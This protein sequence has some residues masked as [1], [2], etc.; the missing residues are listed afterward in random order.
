MWNIIYPSAAGFQR[1]R[2]VPPPFVKG[3]LKGTEGLV[4]EEGSKLQTPLMM[5]K[6]NYSES[7]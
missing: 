5:W 7:I 6:L 1:I 4:L 3:V 2:Q